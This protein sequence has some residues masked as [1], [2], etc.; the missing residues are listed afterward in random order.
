MHRVQDTTW[1]CNAV[2]SRQR[3]LAPLRPLNRDRAHSTI[4][5]Q[6]ACHCLLAMLAIVVLNTVCNNSALRQRLRYIAVTTS[7]TSSCCLRMSYYYATLF[8]C[9]TR[10]LSV[11]VFVLNVHNMGT[12]PQFSF[13]F[14]INVKLFF[15]KYNVFF[16]TCIVLFDN[17][18]SEIRASKPSPP[19]N[20]YNFV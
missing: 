16:N 10:Y 11:L 1:R 7:S 4:N 8:N 19:L 14:K 5:A 3:L 18:T 13:T 20:I 2:R 12:T 6:S 17:V 9:C 15:V